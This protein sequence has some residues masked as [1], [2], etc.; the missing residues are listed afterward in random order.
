[1]SVKKFKK[2]TTVA[3][4]NKDERVGDMFSELGNIESGKLDWWINLKEDY[5]CRSMG[6]GTIHEQTVKECLWLLNND[7]VKIK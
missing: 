5:I 6:C 4:A 2:V 7:V 1:M 3:Q